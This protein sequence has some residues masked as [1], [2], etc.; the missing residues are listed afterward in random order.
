M[1]AAGAMVVT[2]DVG[3]GDGFACAVGAGV[4]VASVDGPELPAEASDDFVVTSLDLVAALLAPT[5]CT[6]FELP[7][8]APMAASKITTIPK[9]TPPW[10]QRGQ[11]R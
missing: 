10:P 2:A 4:G 11:E 9:A 1:E 5:V 6:D 7:P 3:A 8:A